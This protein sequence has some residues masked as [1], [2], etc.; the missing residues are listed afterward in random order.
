MVYN[1]NSNKKNDLRPLKAPISEKIMEVFSVGPWVY[2]LEYGADSNG[3]PSDSPLH[4]IS[5]ESEEEIFQ[6]KC[7]IASNVFYSLGTTNDQYILRWDGISH[8]PKEI[9]VET[10][11]TSSQKEL[12]VHLLR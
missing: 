9:K 4:V 3:V 10:I 6:D 8:D 12:Y 1:S 2:F 7:L 11:R 5:K